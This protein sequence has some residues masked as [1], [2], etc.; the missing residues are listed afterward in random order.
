MRDERTD[1]ELTGLR[2]DECAPHSSSRTHL[3]TF[4]LHGQPGIIPMRR[5]LTVLLITLL[6]PAGSGCRKE[7]QEGKTVDGLTQATLVL[8]WYPE[9]EHGGYYAALVHGYYEEAGLKVKIVPGGPGAAVIPKVD[10]RSA[11]FGVE[12]ADRV[13]LGR[14][15]QADVVAVMAP[16]QTSPRCILVHRQSGIRKLR[17]LKNV[18]L[19]MNPGATW[20][21]FLQKKLPLPGVRIVPSSGIALFLKNDDYAVQGY[22]FS[23]PLVARE[24][25]ANP[26]ALMVSDLGFNPYTSL[27]LTHSKTVKERPEIVRK[28]VEAS[29]RG[30]RKYLEDPEKTNRYIHEQNPKMSLKSLQFGA[31]AM[32]PLCISPQVP[33]DKLGTMTAE[34]WRELAR[35]L[36]EVEALKESNEQG[37]YTLQFIGVK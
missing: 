28:M 32:K 1:E 34:R 15:Q 3:V 33:A 16:L 20:A 8:N 27:L 19:A 18:T 35:Q 25:G 31:E 7:S 14:A 9:A 29:I 24:G 37:A 26:V 21:K 12:N 17:D 23:E 6:F 4:Q 5:A 13:L 2:N 30:W 22:V 11:M 10:D 36:V